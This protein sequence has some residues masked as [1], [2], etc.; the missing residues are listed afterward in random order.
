M[1]IPA[2]E[3]GGLRIAFRWRP[4]GDILRRV[5]QIWTALDLEQHG[6]GRERHQGMPSAIRN[7]D[8]A[9]TAIGIQIDAFQDPAV[10]GEGQHRGAA[11]DGHEQLP[12]RRRGMAVRTQI[13]ARLE[14]I[15]QALHRIIEFG[16]QVQV[17]AQ[18]RRSG[19]F[20]AQAHDGG[21]VD[22]FQ[23]VKFLRCS[24]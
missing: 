1:P 4:G 21:G 6:P 10:I 22:L 8:Q 5:G 24:L 18:A 13:G 20:V 16:V 3:F 12:L 23:D 11:G 2:L 15:Q 14:R 7:L 9:R 17:L 19:G